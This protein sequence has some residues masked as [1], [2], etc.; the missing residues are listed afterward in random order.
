MIS[1]AVLPEAEQMDNVSIIG[2]PGEMAFDAQG[3]LV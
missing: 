1:E 2:S 3:N